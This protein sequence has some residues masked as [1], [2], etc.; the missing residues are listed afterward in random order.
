MSK[1]AYSHYLLEV[2]Q[3]YTKQLSNMLVPVMYEGLISI[4][5]EAKKIKKESPMKT[6]Q[7]LLSRIPQW[8]QNIINNEYQRIVSKTQCDW[9]NDLITAVFIS[10]AKILSS[11][12]TKKN[13]KTL[14][15]KV[16]NGDY[17][18]H[19]AYIECARQFWK[20][21]Y[22]F[23][24]EVNTIE[25]QRNLREV[26]AIIEQS[27][28]ETIRKLLPVKNI[29]QQYI[30]IDESDSSSSEDEEA[31]ETEDE[32]SAL[33]TESKK[34]NRTEEN[35]KY[36]EEYI[37]SSITEKDKKKLEKSVK[38]ELSKATP[39]KDD[40][41]HSIVSL[42][43]DIPNKKPSRKTIVP[44]IVSEPKEEYIESLSKNIDEIPIMDIKS[45]SLE[46][47]KNES[48]DV[49]SKF[50]EQNE[51][52][53]ESLNEENSH[54]ISLDEVKQYPPQIGSHFEEDG[55]EIFKERGSRSLKESSL[56]LD[57]DDMDEFDRMSMN[58]KLDVTYQPEDQIEASFEPS[59]KKSLRIDIDEIPPVE[60]P[61]LSSHVS[62]EQ[63]KAP[64][65]K[66][67]V[68]NMPGGNEIEKPAAA[69]G[70]VRQG[71]AKKREIRKNYRFFD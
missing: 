19:K 2:K 26:E 47:S 25:Y 41:N 54:D 49:P 67:V 21:P 20:T 1:Q 45:L 27:I 65:I 32:R 8:N 38:K 62:L 39:E 44:N 28:N 40:D 12:R 34:K 5:N 18:V 60:E 70:T 69:S 33:K 13:S 9:I 22:L 15:L 51:G 56:V 7:I 23:Y 31:E 61:S 57:R 35:S 36:D 50:R 10:H 37:T 43:H 63:P 55:E 71:F 52:L 46:K 66:T 59:N 64:E 42:S 58:I 68:I 30:A 16:P 48:A 3:E 24:D 53:Y 29:L 4:Y 11:I 17:F 14:N 6:F